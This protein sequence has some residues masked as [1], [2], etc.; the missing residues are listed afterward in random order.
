MDEPNR[1]LCVRCGASWA[2]NQAKRHR[3]D[4]KCASCRMGKAKSIQYG[5][6]RCVP[7]HG[8]FN[9][10]DEPMVNDE[11]FMPGVRVCGHSDCVN[12]EHLKMS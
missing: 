2:V 4:L 3:K 11:L 5:S 12:G 7:W 9:E 10:F 6:E 1:I 8:E